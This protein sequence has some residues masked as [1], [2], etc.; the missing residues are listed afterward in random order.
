MSTVFEERKA[1]SDQKVREAA[2]AMHTAL[3]VAQQMRI[4]QCVYFKTRDRT[5]LSESKRLE[6]E[7]DRLSREALAQVDAP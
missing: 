4:A 7:F 5:A 3:L 6:R 1:E 2:P